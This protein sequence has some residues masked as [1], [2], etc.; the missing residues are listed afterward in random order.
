MPS[1]AKRSDAFAGMDLVRAVAAKAIEKL[2]AN[3]SRTDRIR[4]ELDEINIRWRKANNQIIYAEL[5][6]DQERLAALKAECERC[7]EQTNRL[8]AELNE[9]ELRSRVQKLLSGKDP[10]TVVRK[11]AESREWAPVAD[12]LQFTGDPEAQE[13]AKECASHAHISKRSTIWSDIHEGI[14]R[15]V[16][17]WC[18]RAMEVGR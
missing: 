5:D 15:E 4:A 7:A 9:T 14:N 13:L 8:R 6:D 2:D 16:L 12:I 1:L 10:V 18:D 3:K 17:A 11:L